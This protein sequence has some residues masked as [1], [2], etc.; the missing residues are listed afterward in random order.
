M[1]QYT[2]KA[3]ALRN[4]TDAHCNCAQS[5][6]LT[7]APALG[8]TEEQ[9]GELSRDFDLS[10]GEI[11]N[12]ARKRFIDSLIFGKPPTFEHIRELCKEESIDDG[13][14]AKRIGF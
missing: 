7:F 10:G 4:R 3:Q 8:L 9:A 12:I 6:L 2:E 14:A 5:V 11:E 1:S 13:S